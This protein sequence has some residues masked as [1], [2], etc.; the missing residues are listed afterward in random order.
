MNFNMRNPN[1]FFLSFY[2]PLSCPY[3]EL[4]DLLYTFAHYL[5]NARKVSTKCYHI[6]NVKCRYS[7]TYLVNINISDFFSLDHHNIVGIYCLSTFKK[8][9]NYMRVPRVDIC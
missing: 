7:R 6:E 4:R 9:D 8:I 3:L 1:S 2:S 5:E